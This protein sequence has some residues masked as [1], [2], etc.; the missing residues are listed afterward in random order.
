MQNTIAK[1]TL[2]EYVMRNEVVFQAFGKPTTNRMQSEARFMIAEVRR[3]KTIVNL[4]EVAGR[5]KGLEDERG[6]LFLK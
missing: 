4:V 6:Q 3:R 1:D 2:R 5:Q